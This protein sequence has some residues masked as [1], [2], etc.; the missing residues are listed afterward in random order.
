MSREVEAEFYQTG[1]AD[2][3]DGKCAIDSPTEY[4][5]EY[6]GWQAVFTIAKDGL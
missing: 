3:M 5:G 2:G 4:E 6:G 1:F